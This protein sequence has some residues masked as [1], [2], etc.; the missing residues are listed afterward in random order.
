MAAPN[1]V[2]QLAVCQAG[3]LRL[4][5]MVVGLVVAGLLAS[6]MVL[7]SDV[8]LVRS[9]ASPK[10]A[11][12]YDK[13][14][15]GF[16]REYGGSITILIN[17]G[18]LSDRKLLVK[19]IRAMTPKIV[20]AV[21]LNAARSLHRQIND[22]PL[23]YCMVSRAIQY[24]LKTPNTTGVMMQPA[25]A[26]QLLAFRRLMPKLRRLG[27]IYHPKL[28]GL[29]IDS[30]RRAAKGLGLDLVEFPIS[31]HQEVLK[32]LEAVLGSTE[33]LWLIRDG[34]VVTHEFFTQVLLVQ[35]EREFPVMVFSE[36]FVRKGALCS[37]SSSYEQQGR[38]AARIANTLLGDT[39]PS[40]IP[41]RSP[42]GKL[43]IN[44]GTANR[45]GITIPASLLGQQDVLLVGK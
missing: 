31:S 15:D 19:R 2:L 7:A 17:E 30:A 21:G 9:Q 16:E 24:K 28:S 3:Q 26:K 25:P 42:E 43:V 44:L 33:S 20:V 27:V 40:S 18:E 22:I 11:K 8:I 6:S 34:K 14:L 35:A 41:I 4:T 13:A 39:R 5:T 32:A 1:G 12:L 23:I 38:E 10:A 45:I 36:Q 29:F 37:F